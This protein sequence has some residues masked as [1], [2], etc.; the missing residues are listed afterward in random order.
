MINEINI[1]IGGFDDG[2]TP[3]VQQYDAGSR[4]YLCRLWE[5][6]GKPYQMAEDAVVGVVF[7]WKGAPPSYEYKTQVM[8]RS[9]VL[10]TVPAAATQKAGTVTMQ[11]VIHE[12]GGDLHGPEISFYAYK[13][14]KPGE[15]E[16]DEPVMLLVAL[17]NRVDEQVQKVNEA[18][19]RVEQMQIDASGLAGDSNKLGGQLPEYYLPAT[20]TAADSSML[21]GKAP[22]YY[23]QPRNLLDNSDFRNPI[24]QRGI[25]TSGAF[26]YFI[27]RWITG[28]AGCTLS[29]DG[30]N[31]V[32]N[33]WLHQRIAKETFDTY[34]SNGFTFCCETANGDILTLNT[35]GGDGSGN[36]NGVIL[37][38]ANDHLESAGYYEFRI[39][40][41]T[42]TTCIVKWAALYEGEYTAETL[43]PYIPKGYAAEL[44][45][46]QRYFYSMKG[47]WKWMATGVCE[48]S[49]AAN[50][51]V[52][53]P[54]AMRISPTI[55]I[56]D[57]SLVK[58]RCGSEASQVPS[59]ISW[60]YATTCFDMMYL[61]ATVTGATSGDIA[62]LYFDNGGEIQFSADL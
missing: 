9:T 8:D 53:L 52:R 43:P 62:V 38:V 1:Y 12:N 27:D 32:S 20:G 44:A 34:L 16:T 30:V 36:I 7:D 25:T 11:L 50:I 42:S 51:P 28:S 13:S 54:Q 56:P 47:Y 46:C 5:S 55:T 35:V 31:M 41:D 6:A 61:Q 40:T 37:Y 22:Q 33:C 3:G 18:A 4:K 23:I 48:S 19:D 15:N 17:M 10:V 60:N 21:G 24:N 29:A 59:A 45:E 57:E 2:R 14:L 39:I 49:T 58:V 26:A